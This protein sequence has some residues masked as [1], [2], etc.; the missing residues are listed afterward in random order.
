MNKQKLC[1]CHIIQVNFEN[2]DG[3]VS[4]VNVRNN[5][6]MFVVSDET[7]CFCLYLYIWALS[8]LSKM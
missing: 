4:F 2:F 3:A 5:H 7:S 6:W 8:K 1:W